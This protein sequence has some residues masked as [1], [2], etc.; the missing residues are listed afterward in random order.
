MLIKQFDD[1][2]GDDTDSDF[3]RIKIWKGLKSI[4][5]FHPNKEH[6]ELPY[7]T[8]GPKLKFEIAI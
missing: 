3:P 1:F 8:Q 5:D 4:W 6:Y 2:Y 7:L